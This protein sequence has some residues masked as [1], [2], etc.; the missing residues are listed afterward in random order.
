MTPASYFSC[1]YTRQVIHIEDPLAVHPSGVFIQNRC[2]IVITDIFVMVSHIFRQHKG[3]KGGPK[4][5]F[6][7][8]D[9]IINMEVIGMVNRNKSP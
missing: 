7:A 3:E 9:Y 5:P 2:T 4:L 1:F 6:S 8:I